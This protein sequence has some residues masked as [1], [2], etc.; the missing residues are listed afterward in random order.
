MP[1]RTVIRVDGVVA[2]QLAADTCSHRLLTDAEMDEPVHLVRTRQLSDALLE[3]ADPPHRA[4][5]LEAEVGFEPRR[6][7]LRHGR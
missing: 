5:E 4:E 3:D 2:T 1:V 6:H 7:V